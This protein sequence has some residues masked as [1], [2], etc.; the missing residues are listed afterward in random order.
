MGRGSSIPP[1]QKLSPPTG[2]TPPRRRT[3]W[4]TRCSLPGMTVTCCGS[5]T[6]RRLRP[7][8]SCSASCPRPTQRWPSGG[9]S[10]RRT[11]SRGPRSWR[12]P[13]ESRAACLWQGPCVSRPQPSPPLTRPAA[14]V[15]AK[16][17]FDNAEDPAP[18]PPPSPLRKAFCSRYV[19]HPNIRRTKGLSEG[20]VLP[21]GAGCR[22]R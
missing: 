19:S 17:G 21:P 14:G 9:P 15:D 8:P 13:S 5:S 12:R 3:P 11:P 16:L 22:G 1:S 10:M 18:A 6:R 4:L 20:R 2:S 7:R